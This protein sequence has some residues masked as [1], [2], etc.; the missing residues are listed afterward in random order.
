MHARD[1]CFRFLRSAGAESG[2]SWDTARLLLLGPV[3]AAEDVDATNFAGT[4][5]NMSGTVLFYAV[6]HDFA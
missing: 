4:S 3:S 1:I 6:P 5:G 2:A